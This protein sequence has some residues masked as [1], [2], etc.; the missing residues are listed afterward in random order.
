[1]PPTSLARPNGPRVRELRKKADLTQGQLAD[2]IQR[3]RATVMR[4]ELGLPVS[5]I[6]M[7]QIARRF[8]VSLASITLPDEPGTE[9]GGEDAAGPDVP[10][11][12]AA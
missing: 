10:A 6:V 9:S 4:A 1:M 7:R 12:E 11:D 3:H 5:K 2:R 8:H